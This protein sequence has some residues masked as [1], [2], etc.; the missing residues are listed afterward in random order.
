MTKVRY[1][2]IACAEVWSHSAQLEWLCYLPANTELQSV[3]F[4]TLETLGL[5]VS[6]KAGLPW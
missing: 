6:F 2:H 5:P 3:A 4:Y 1:V